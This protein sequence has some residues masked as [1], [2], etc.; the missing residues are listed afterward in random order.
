[1][2]P[3]FTYG[4]VTYSVCQGIRHAL[5]YLM[6][7][8]LGTSQFSFTAPAKKTAHFK[9]DQKWL[10]NNHLASFVKVQS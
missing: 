4:D 3:S 5:L 1:M 8:I 2:A 9:S 6:V 7:W 10:T